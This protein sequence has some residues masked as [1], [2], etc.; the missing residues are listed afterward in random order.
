MKQIQEP[1]T[2]PCFIFGSFHGFPVYGPNKEI[3]YENIFYGSTTSGIWPFPVKVLLALAD[4]MAL[5]IPPSQ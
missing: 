5:M 2:L 4:N 1:F 3:N